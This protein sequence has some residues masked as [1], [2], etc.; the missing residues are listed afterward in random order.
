MILE[1]KHIRRGKRK[2]GKCKRKKEQKKRE[3]LKLKG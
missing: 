1:E 2:G 3:N